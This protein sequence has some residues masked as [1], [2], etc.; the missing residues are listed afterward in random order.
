MQ[1]VK[2]IALMAMMVLSLW[3]CAP[4]E[5]DSPSVPSPKT[6]AQSLLEQLQSSW[7]YS[8]RD[9]R[10]VSEMQELPDS[11]MLLF[12]S[13][14][15]RWSQAQ[16]YRGKRQ[17]HIL[18]IPLEARHSVRLLSSELDSTLRQQYSDR[19][20]SRTSLLSITSDQGQRNYFL[21]LIPNLSYLEAGGELPDSVLIP[22]GFS[23]S[24]MLF[25]MNHQLVQISRLEQGKRAEELR[26]WVVICYYKETIA[27]VGTDSGQLENGRYYK[28]ICET[29]YFPDSEYPR[30]T[31]IDT[32]FAD[33]FLGRDEP[34]YSSGWAPLD[35][36]PPI[37]RELLP[38][39][40][41][42]LLNKQGKNHLDSIFKDTQHRLWL[43]S[44]DEVRPQ[45]G[46]HQKYHRHHSKN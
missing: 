23:G 42:I 19:D 38:Q 24:V 17:E 32:G 6:E 13:V 41:K 39:D 2:S 27:Y 4:E 18:H 40:A 33:P 25:D 14:S 36:T 31:E 46:C 44:T 11:L 37:L 5:V 8:P 3:S 15:P 30:D 10:S 26:A 21:H 20:L 29:F 43:Q 22:R 9:L 7:S 12:A 35:D 45:Y 16:Y 1:R 34:P 28:R